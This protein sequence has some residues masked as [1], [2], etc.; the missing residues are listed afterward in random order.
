M[1]A[2]DIE[3]TVSELPPLVANPFVTDPFVCPH[4]VTY[5]IEPTSEQR[6]IW[7]RDQTP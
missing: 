6:A 3:I 4:G 2:M 7:N 1:A 5:W